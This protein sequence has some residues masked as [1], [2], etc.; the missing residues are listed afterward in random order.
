MEPCATVINVRSVGGYQ[1]EL[2]FADGL[3][4]IVD[5]WGRIRGR[6]G[7]F[8]MLKDPAF[9]RQVRVDPELGTVVWPNEVDV[10]PELLHEWV[11]AGR[12][13][14]CEPEDVRQEA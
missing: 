7:D 8:E 14:A 2:T 3:S 5:L 10:C 1:L 12:V 9:F 4:G 6:S 11:A 13:A